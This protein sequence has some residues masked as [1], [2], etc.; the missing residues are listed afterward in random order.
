[1]VQRTAFDNLVSVF[2]GRRQLGDGVLRSY[3]DFDRLIHD[4]LQVS[5]FRYAVESLGQPEKIVVEGIGISRTTLGRRKQA[6][7]LDF[8][9]SE[10]AVRLGSIVALGK[11]VLGSTKAVGRWLLKPNSA[12]GG[13][14]PIALLQTDV[15]AREVEAVLGRDLFGGFS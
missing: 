8:V 12:L 13:A 15:G 6:G 11:V 9:D 10:R 2:G 1:M 4:G 7:R 5:A 3:L 14:I